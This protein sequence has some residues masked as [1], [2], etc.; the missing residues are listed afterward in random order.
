[1]TL[2]L[3]D[4]FFLA[5]CKQSF[6]VKTKADS[7]VKSQNNHEK[8]SV[9]TQ[10]ICLHFARKNVKKVLKGDFYGLRGCCRTCL[11]EKADPGMSGFRKWRDRL[12]WVCLCFECRCR[13]CTRYVYGK[14]MV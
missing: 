7:K 6:R 5:F 8:C 3:A 11:R 14:C 12:R 1:M 2:I 9:E 4:T 13:R 10:N